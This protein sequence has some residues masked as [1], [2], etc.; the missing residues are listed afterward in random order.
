MSES[1]ETNYTAQDIRFTTKNENLYAICLDWPSQKLVISSLAKGG[2]YDK[3]I[4]S[5]SLLGYDQEL[6]WT[7]TDQG[8]ILDFP[9]D[10]VGN[11]AFALKIR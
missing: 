10:Q 8:L 6:D 3:E 7:Q 11:Y 9:A 4:E 1:Q 2:I 5:V